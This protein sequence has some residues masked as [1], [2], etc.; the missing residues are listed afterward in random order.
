MLQAGTFSKLFAPGVRLGWAVG[1]AEVITELAA[2]K[3]TTDQCSGA[4][5]QRVVEEYGKAGHF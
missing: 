3:Q 1:P 4:L 2:A 5:G